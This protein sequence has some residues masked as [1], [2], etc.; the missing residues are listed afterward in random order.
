MERGDGVDS[1][2]S[3][4]EGGVYSVEIVISVLVRL[5]LDNITVLDSLRI[6]I[7]QILKELKVASIPLLAPLPMPW[8]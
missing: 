7:C 8:A 5:F 6:I 4:E 2:V 1:L 3:E